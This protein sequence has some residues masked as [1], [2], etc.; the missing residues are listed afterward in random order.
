MINA[1]NILN[2]IMKLSNTK[3]K[4]G[5]KNYRT[6]SLIE[7]AQNTISYLSRLIQDTTLN[8][9]TQIILDDKLSRTGQIKRPLHS[10][11]ASSSKKPKVAKK[12]SKV[13]QKQ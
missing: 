10:R 6:N 7:S 12:Q 1:V 11:T 4:G 2:N 9:K 13:I 3:S 8:K 5:V